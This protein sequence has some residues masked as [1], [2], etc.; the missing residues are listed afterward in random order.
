MNKKT[1]ILVITNVVIIIA[2]LGGGIGYVVWASRQYSTPIIAKS[3]RKIGGPPLT[4]DGPAGL[5]ETDQATYIIT[6]RTEAGCRLEIDG[7][8]YSVQPDGAFSISVSLVKGINVFEV[9]A[10]NKAGGRTQK[11]A[12]FN[13]TS[14]N[15]IVH[16]TVSPR[17]AIVGQWRTPADKYS[18]WVSQ[19]TYTVRRNTD[20][21][22]YSGV[23]SI[24]STDEK[25]FYAIVDVSASDGNHRIKITFAPDK[26]HATLTE[27]NNSITVIF[28]GANQAP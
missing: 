25:A 6:G 8:K 9:V 28:S 18:T 10:I 4:I 20:G 15:A 12:S 21:L 2:V 1:V 13:C 23:Y 26:R 24:V 27:G 7:I 16:D 17:E 19:N 5:V 22:T 14:L 3:E 11:E